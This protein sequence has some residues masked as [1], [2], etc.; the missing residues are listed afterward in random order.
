MI[1]TY[2]VLKGYT[3]MLGNL[4]LHLSL[5]IATL[6][7]IEVPDGLDAKTGNDLHRLYQSQLALHFMSAIIWA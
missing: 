2:S 7:Y 5:A 4:V 6:I 3:A 1:Y